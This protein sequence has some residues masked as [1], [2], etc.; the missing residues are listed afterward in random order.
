MQGTKLLES[1]DLKL[2]ISGQCS[3]VVWSVGPDKTKRVL[4]LFEERDRN[5]ITH[6]EL[7]RTIREV[8]ME[9][10]SDGAA[11]SSLCCA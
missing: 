4:R 3:R 1:G 5:A 2:E 7:K 8:L 6:G 9:G 11:L 10:Q